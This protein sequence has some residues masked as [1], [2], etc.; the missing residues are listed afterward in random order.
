[1]NE[2]LYLVLIKS[3]VK[4]VHVN[5]LKR[6]IEKPIFAQSTSDAAVTGVQD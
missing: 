6:F 5:K 4:P 1:M 3:E 2:S